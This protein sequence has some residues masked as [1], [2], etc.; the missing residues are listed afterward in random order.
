MTSGHGQRRAVG[1]I[2]YLPQQAPPAGTDRVTSRQ[3][4][5][6]STGDY[7]RAR[8]AEDD[9][10]HWERVHAARTVACN[11]H[12]AQDL[13]LLLS[14]LGLD[15]ADHRGEPETGPSAVR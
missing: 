11:A 3:T 12:G 14:I 4:G 2:P 1:D 7:S 10:A 5:G 9:H 6:H 13:L 15:A 8:A